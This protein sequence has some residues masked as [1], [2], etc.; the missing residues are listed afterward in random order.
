VAQSSFRTSE[1]IIACLFNS[2]KAFLVD[3]FTNSWLWA[4]VIPTSMRSL[5]Y[6][7]I[8]GLE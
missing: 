4:K 1:Q 3:N 5:F 2:P 8:S 7:A 6:S